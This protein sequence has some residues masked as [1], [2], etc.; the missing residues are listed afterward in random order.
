MESD[1][2]SGDGSEPESEPT[3]GQR[4]QKKKAKCCHIGTEDEASDVKVV[5]TD[6]KLLPSRVKEV[7][8]ISG[9]EQQVSMMFLL[10]FTT[11]LT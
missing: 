1:S 6:V 11:K 10:K 2:E 9:D 4:Q 8:D 5:K 3:P 7:D